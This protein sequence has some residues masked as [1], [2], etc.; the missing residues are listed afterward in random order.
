MEKEFTQKKLKELLSYDE[1]TGVF[2]WLVNMGSNKVKGINAGIDYRT[3]QGKSYRRIRIERKHY[4]SHRLAWL[5]MTGELPENDIDHI[6]GNGLNNSFN[7]LRSVTRVENCR[8]MRKTSR[9]KS[10]TTGV[11]WH[12]RDKAWIARIT[13]I[14]RDVYLGCFSNIVDAIIAR[15]MAEY[16]FGFHPNHGSVRGL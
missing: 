3:K 5:Y 12:K 7:N 15:K 11:Y 6:D 1:N 9:N 10:G 13:V 4:Q 14:S 8:N 16:E 2:V